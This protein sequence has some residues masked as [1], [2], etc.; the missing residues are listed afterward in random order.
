MSSDLSLVLVIVGFAVVQS[1]FGV[2]LL[3]FG[4]PA[5]LLMGLSFETTLAYL[6]PTSLVI[7]ALQLVGSGGVRLDAMRR[8]FLVFTAPLVIIGTAFILTAGAGMDIQLIVGAMLIVSGI[9]RLMEPVRQWASG[10]ARRHLPWFLSVLG[11]VHGLSN[12]GGGV[13]TVIVGAVYDDKNEIRS[14]IAFGYG[15]MALLQLITLRITSPQL[16]VDRLMLLLLPV[17]AGLIYLLAGN[18]AFRAASQTAF[19]AAL[20]ALIIV[21][22]LLLVVDPRP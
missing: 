1:V 9:I 11:G 21:F 15:L 20:T 14:Q 8:Q 22:G 13:L 2:G 5:L 10:L 19:Q 4:T 7:S 12:L 16:D 6:L 17:L 18:R 3:V